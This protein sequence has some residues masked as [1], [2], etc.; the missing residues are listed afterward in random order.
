MALTRALGRTQ[1]LFFLTWNKCVPFNAPAP[2]QG[3]IPPHFHMVFSILKSGQAHVFLPKVARKWSPKSAEREAFIIPNGFQGPSNLQSYHTWEIQTT[4][5]ACDR[6]VMA[7]IKHELLPF[8]FKTITC[9][10]FKNDYNSIE[11]NLGYLTSKLRLCCIYH[12][13]V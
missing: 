11:T 4:Y 5:R 9:S 10:S 8:F 2:T 12:I 7:I 13:H 6:T 1:I 3:L